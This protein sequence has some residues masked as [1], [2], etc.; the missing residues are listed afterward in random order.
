MDLSTSFTGE[1][2]LAVSIL[3]GN[4]STAVDAVMDGSMAS[5]SDT[6]EV[7]EEEIEVELGTPDYLALDGISYTFPLG[8]FTVV[9]GDGVGVDELNT[10]ACSYSAFTAVSYTHLR[11][12]ETR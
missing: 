10:G 5:F 4:G 12:H 7:E 8:G 11:A 2:A 3:G 1:D 9:T 6:I